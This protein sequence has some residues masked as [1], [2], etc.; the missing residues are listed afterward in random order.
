ME[1]S[2]S[3][4]GGSDTPVDD[5]WGC[6]VVNIHALSPVSKLTSGANGA[7]EFLHFSNAFEAE[8]MMYL[9]AA[10]KHVMDIDLMGKGRVSEV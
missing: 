10:M 8:L 1:A 6:V 2:F 5:E 7:R 3:L 4:P 9:E